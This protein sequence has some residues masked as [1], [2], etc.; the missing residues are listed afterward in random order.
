[1]KIYVSTV[2]KVAVILIKYR[3]PSAAL[4]R[5]K[6]KMGLLPRVEGDPVPL[7]IKENRHVADIFF[8]E[9][10]RLKNFTSGRF[11]PGELVIQ[12]AAFSSVIDQ[13]TVPPVHP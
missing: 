1:M 11:H 9:G 13:H 8:D 10:F 2:K 3:T 6:Q 7:G 4:V 12:I 5:L